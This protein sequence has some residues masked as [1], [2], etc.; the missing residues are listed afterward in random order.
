MHLSH[1]LNHLGEDREKYFNAV[2]PPI[3]QTSNF[4]FKTI[5]DFKAAFNDELSSHIYSRGN[6]PTV[7]ILRKKIAALE[8]AEDALVF[9]SGVAAISMA[10][11]A[12]V[13]AGAHVVSVN[14]PYSWTQKLLEKF[15]SRFGVTHT[16]VDGT[17]IAAIKAAI[18]P[19]TRVLFLE[20]PNSVTFAIQDLKACADLAKEHGIISIID[21]SYASPLYQKPIDFGIDIVTHSATKYLNGHSD[22]VAGVLAGSKEMIKKIFESEFMT[23]GALLAPNDASLL[24]RGLR[25]LELRMERSNT[26]TLKITKWLEDHPK[27]EKIIYPFSPSFPQ[28]DLAKK[29]MGGTG[30]LFSIQLKAKSI[31]KVEDFFHTLQHFLLAVSWGGHESLVLPFCAFYDIPGRDN[32]SVPWNLVRFYVGLEDPDWLIEDLKRAFAVL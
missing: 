27:V 7:D 12:N 28:Y 5:A 25:T 9:G 10:V 31:Q 23:L 2:A 16:Y 20:S 15:L 21:N 8:H 26:S 3:I 32:P 13:E 6:N 29:Q 4:S 11:I 30:G 18:Q 17:D 19:N 24:I 22:V 14:A 1:I